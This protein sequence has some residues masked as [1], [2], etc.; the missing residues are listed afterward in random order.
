MV[1]EWKCF[2]FLF[3]F[4]VK[5]VS[6]FHD[7]PSYL[8]TNKVQIKLGICG[9]WSPKLYNTSILVAFLSDGYDVGGLWYDL[10]SD[11]HIFFVF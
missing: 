8:I 6:I 3:L 10:S 4:A 9:A 11:L 5:Y 1:K 2:P 7:I